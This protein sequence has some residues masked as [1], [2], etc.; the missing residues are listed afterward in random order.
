VIGEYVPCSGPRSCSQRSLVGIGVFQDLSKHEIVS[1]ERV[2]QRL[3]DE[4]EDLQPVM[5]FL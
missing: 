4:E 2:E 1:I 5:K 3:A